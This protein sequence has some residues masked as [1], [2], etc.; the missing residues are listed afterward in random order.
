VDRLVHCGHCAV[1]HHDCVGFT[2]IDYYAFT[3]YETLLEEFKLTALF[4]D[5]EGLSPDQE[6]LQGFHLV[7]YYYYKI[8]LIILFLNYTSNLMS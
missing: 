2:I 4:L 6:V 7:N 5:H 3:S 1:G 8:R